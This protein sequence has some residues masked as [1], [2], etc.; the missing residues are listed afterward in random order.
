MPL[1]PRPLF[2]PDVL[3][4]SWTEFLMPPQTDQT[5]QMLDHWADLIGSNRID[6]LGEQAD[7]S[8][9]PH[10]LLLRP[11]RLHRPGR[12]RRTLHHLPRAA[13]R[14]GRQIRRRR[15]RRF[16]RR[17]ALRRRRRRQGPARP[18]RPALRRPPDVGRRSGLPLRHQP[19]LRL[20]HRHLDA[21]RRGSI[22]KA[23]TSTPTS[24]ST[25]SSWPTTKPCS[26][27]SSSCSAP[28]ASC[29]PPATATSTSCWP[30]PEQVGRELT[31]EFYVRYADMRQDAF[32][33]LCRDNPAVAPHDV[34]RQHAEAARPRP[35]LSPSARTAAC[36]PPK[37]SAEP[38]S[39]AT[40][41]TRGRSGRTSA[42]CSGAINDGN[43]APGHPRL[44]RRAV[45]RRSASSTRSACP[46]RSARYFQDLGDYDYRPP[47]E[48][49]DDASRPASSIDVDI[50]GHIFEQS[51]TDLERLRNELDGLAEPLGAEKHKTRR[52]KEGAFYTPS[53]ITR[54]IVEQALGGVLS[55]RFEQLCASQHA[56][57]AAKARARN[58]PWPIPRVYDLDS[59]QRTR[60]DGARSASG[61]P[62]RTSWP[63]IRLLDPACGSG[64][65]LIE[66]FDQLHAAYQQLERP[67]GRTARP[68][69]ALRP[70]PAD[71]AEQ[72]L[73]RG[74]QRG[75][76][77][78][79]PA[80]PLDQDRRSA[81]RR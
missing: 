17:Q 12:R 30:T 31:K 24:A 66:A 71:S 67:A 10:R 34:L 73:R 1:E 60:S 9:F 15:A 70:R 7:S 41:T 68:S 64:A 46:T 56:D 42:A 47:H 33:Q 50:L 8:R 78:N 4:H 55:D 79:L 69:H 77:R 20:D 27:G 53:F 14:G 22:T 51:I 39:T 75:G 80:Q 43:A 62:G 63:R 52:K 6:R 2:R 11:A 54:Y 40:P 44:Q 49:A 19:A 58:A 3:R 23:R 37:P 81:A 45:R 32:E 38:T 16:Q 36:C 5:R 59:A 18:A 61:K 29:P 35:V 28:S 21:R 25:P 13:R 72:P 26:D 65:F 48:A 74:P 57:E 76:H